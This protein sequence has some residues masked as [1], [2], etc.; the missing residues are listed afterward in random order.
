MSMY[1]QQADDT[2]YKYKTV[3]N[4]ATIPTMQAAILLSYPN[5]QM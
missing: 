3:D 2:A 4:S 5:P 1:K